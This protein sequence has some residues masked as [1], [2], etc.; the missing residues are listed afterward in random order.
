[1][2]KSLSIFGSRIF[3]TFTMWYVPM[4]WVIA[5][6][7][8]SGC[9]DLFSE[10]SVELESRNILREISQVDLA[11]NPDLQIPDIYR[12]PPQ[13]LEGITAGKTD[14]RLFYFSRYTIVTELAK[15]VNEQYIKKFFDPKGKP[16][17][18]VD[19]SVSV[20]AGTNQIIVRCPTVE[21]A[22]QVQHFLEQVDVPPVQIKID[23]LISEVYADHTMDW[24]TTLKI[25]NLL[26]QKINLGG[27][28]TAAAGLLPAF[29]GAALRDAARAG[30]G[31]KTGYILNEGVK[32]HEFRALV[33]IL[34]SRGYLKI[35]MNPTLEVVNGQTATIETKEHVPLDEVSYV[36]SD[37]KVITTSKRYEDVVDSLKVTPYVFA[38][39][40]IGITTEAVIG[41]KST[42]EGVS[43]ISIL[44]ERKITIAEN[45]IRPGE[46]LVVGGITKTEKRAVVRGVP[47]LKDIP[48]LGVLFSSKDFEERG[49]EVLFIL[50]PTISTGGRPNAE[51]M[52]DIRRKHEMI[53]TKTTLINTLKDPF[54]K[55]QYVELVEKKAADARAQK[56]QAQSKANR[57][58]QELRTTKQR[59]ESEKLNKERAR[60]ETVEVA[61]ELQATKKQYLQ[62]KADYED[63]ISKWMKEQQ[64]NNP[65]P[66]PANP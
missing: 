13:I 10:K 40:S 12:Q 46:S 16:Y 58:R 2:I 38:D 27:K 65:K 1:M 42:P 6:L 4:L 44:T 33:D 24:E 17:P 8:L 39:G 9:G 66:A 57:L 60:K 29:P 19:Y 43:Q 51:V 59:T 48:L 28:E 64:K 50:T 11:E 61:S 25:E 15:L 32:G 3:I 7:T 30:L 56:M 41:S 63:A 55:K 53:K 49:K 34:V 45:R 31:L 62:M 54:G 35:L 37:G 21:D 22:K 47:L 23:C 26:G 18:V 5:L 20:N 52:R 36:N 14:A